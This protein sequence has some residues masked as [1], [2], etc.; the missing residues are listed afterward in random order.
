MP[1]A[2]SAVRPTRPAHSDINHDVSPAHIPSP[3]PYITAKF[4]DSFYTILHFILLPF[5]IAFAYI[6]GVC[7]F[8]N[9]A[10]NGSLRNIDGSSDF[11]EW[12]PRQ[13]Q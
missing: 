3:F 13:I 7:D 8:S 11:F 5:K 10:W 12:K 2:C 9:A 1:S 4:Y 6:K